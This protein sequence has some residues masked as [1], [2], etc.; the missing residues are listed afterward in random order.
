M[1]LVATKDSNPI[2]SA[3]G[4]TFSAQTN[5]Q[6]Q[7][8]SFYSEPVLLPAS[9]V[10]TDFDTSWEESVC[11]LAFWRPAVWKTRRGCAQQ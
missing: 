4:I 1:A 8:H 11:S 3:H 9:A 6:N 10:D 5:P 2:Y 7:N